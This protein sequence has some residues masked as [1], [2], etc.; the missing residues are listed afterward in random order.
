MKPTPKEAIVLILAC[1]VFIVIVVPVLGS[2]IG[3]AIHGEPV[4]RPEFLKTAG[5]IVIYILGILSGY[6][7]NNTQPKE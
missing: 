6:V 5:D 3:S 2:T 4:N 7:L 1:L